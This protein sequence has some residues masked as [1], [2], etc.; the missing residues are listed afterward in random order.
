MTEF[1]VQIPWFSWEGAPGN[2]RTVLGDIAKTAEDA[3]FS[4]L[5]VMDHF[6]QLPMIGDATLDMH[7]SYTTLGF[8]AG[9]TEKITLGALVTGV[10][11]RHPA[12]LV[13]AATT[14]DVLSGGRAW[15]AIG[16]AWFEREHLG[17][18]V[19][20]P[21]V[22]ERFERLEEALQIAKQMWSPDDGPYKGEHYTLEETI[23]SPQPIQKPHPPIMVGGSGEKKTLRLVAKYADAC[24][25]TGITGA[26]DLV[27]Q[28]FDVLKRHCD[29]VGRDYDDIQ[30]T[31]LLTAFPGMDLA[32]EAKSLIDLGASH[33]IYN[34]PAIDTLEPVRMIGKEVVSA[35]S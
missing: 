8:F 5:W 19:A 29:D 14:L 17:L 18:G 9:I 26:P 20:F 30:K 15:F 22:K 10:T 24:N 11:Y 34:M 3:G 32:G 31:C 2:Q 16:A 12:V 35:F 25:I 6:F 7:E 13:K 28:K 21:P 23:C 4:S 27:R 1:G 33:L